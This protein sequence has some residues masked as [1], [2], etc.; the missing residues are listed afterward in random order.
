MKTVLKKSRFPQKAE[1]DDILGK[2]RCLRKQQI[3]KQRGEIM[4]YWENGK[5]KQQTAKRMLRIMKSELEKLEAEDKARLFIHNRKS[6]IYFEAATKTEQKGIS[7]DENRVCLLARKRY[8]EI[9]IRYCDWQCQ[10]AERY[11]AMAEKRR[12]LEK[13]EKIFSA[14]EYAGFDLRKVTYSAKQYEW[15]TA[16]FKGN[17]FAPEERKWETP[18]GVK[19]RSKSERDIGTILE[20]MGVPY[21]YEAPVRVDVSWMTDESG[22]PNVSGMAP[23]GMKTYYP[24]FTIMCFDGSI[25]ILE[26]FGLLDLPGYRNKTGEKIAAMRGS[27]FLDDAHFIMTTEKDMIE[28]E[29]IVRIVTERILPLVRG[30]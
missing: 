21:R 11:R 26:H 29:T 5:T 16:D 14:I 19:M 1:K 7:K 17:P 13:L 27:G 23:D 15:A 20:R 18:G 12:K 6:G 30:V 22:I 25:L 4:R 2:R 24:D 10:Q 8:L 9:E 28:H 3:E